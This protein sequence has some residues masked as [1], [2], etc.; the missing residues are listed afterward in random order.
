SLDRSSELAGLAVGHPIR[1]FVRLAAE[2]EHVH[3]AVEGSSNVSWCSC[4]YGPR[5]APG[6]G[7]LLELLN[8][9][10]R[11]HIVDRG[12]HRGVSFRF[13]FRCC[14]YVAVS[15]GRLLERTF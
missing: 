5:T 12:G 7:S 3:A 10:F 13:G 4:L 15:D 14:W 11:D 1:R 9:S 6:H 2:K 8:D